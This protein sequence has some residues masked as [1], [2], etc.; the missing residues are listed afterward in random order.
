M[1]LAG[2]GSQ[3]SQDQKVQPHDGPGDYLKKE[4]VR[5]RER[6]RDIERDIPNLGPHLQLLNGNLH[7]PRA[8]GD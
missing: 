7:F 5:E 6:E 3:V 2:S 8:A 4:R 1:L